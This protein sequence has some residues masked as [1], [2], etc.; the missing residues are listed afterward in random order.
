ML[1]ILLRRTLARTP[2]ERARRERHTLAR[3]LARIPDAARQQPVS[4]RGLG[5]LIRPGVAA[6]CAPTALHLAAALV[7]PHVDVDTAALA[8]IRTFLTDGCTSPLYDR[9][10]EAAFLGL[11]ELASRVLAT[12]SADQAALETA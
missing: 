5:P 3:G 4:P 9:S 8:E 12:R 10:P 2:E 1:T 7:D 11:A 6:A